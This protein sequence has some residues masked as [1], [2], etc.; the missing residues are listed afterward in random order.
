MLVARMC[1]ILVADVARFDAGCDAPAPRRAAAN[2]TPRPV[3][4]THI[5]ERASGVD[6]RNPFGDL[7]VVAG[8]QMGEA[9]AR[10]CTTC[11][12]GAPAMRS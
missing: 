12:T 3:R 1:Q 7:D 10:V 6:G 9:F 4:D 11:G 5:G 8:G 2:C